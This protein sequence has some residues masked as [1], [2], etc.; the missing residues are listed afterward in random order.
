[1]RAKAVRLWPLR[2]SVG[3]VERV[4][5]G[6]GEAGSKVGRPTQSARSSSCSPRV[7]RKPKGQPYRAATHL[8]YVPSS[9]SSQCDGSTR[10]RR[11]FA[12]KMTRKQNSYLRANPEVVRK[13]CYRARDSSVDQDVDA[14]ICWV[15]LCYQGM[16]ERRGE[17][18]VPPARAETRASSL[19]LCVCW[20]I[21]LRR[22]CTRTR[23][24]GDGTAAEAKAAGC[25][26][27]V[28]QAVI[29]ADHARPLREFGS[30][31]PR[32]SPSL[33]SPGPVLLLSRRSVV[34]TGPAE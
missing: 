3:A 13:G 12:R 29:R 8:V 4:R 32:Q 1:M 26:G 19:R 6:F 34:R 10:R 2:C 9:G 15:E 18:E 22:G 7:G 20:I 23:S 5:S 21:R 11:R 16:G 30:P 27:I 25:A 28:E 17:C 31:S 33:A 14:R 24:H